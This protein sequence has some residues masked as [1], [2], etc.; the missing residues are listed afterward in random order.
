VGSPNIQSYLR[1]NGITTSDIDSGIKFLD[2]F[3][4]KKGDITKLKFIIPTNETKSQDTNLCNRIRNPNIDCQVQIMVSSE[5]K[6]F[7]EWLDAGGFLAFGKIVPD[8]ADAI[9]VIVLLFG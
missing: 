5:D 3:T 6:T 1:E 7:K 9:C 4:N 8:P 2:V